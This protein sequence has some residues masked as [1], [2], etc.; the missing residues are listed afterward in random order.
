M[1]KS[2]NPL[3]DYSRY[4]SIAIQMVVIIGGGVLGGYYLDRW[5]NW[6]FPVFTVSFSFLSVALAIFIT[7]REFLRPKK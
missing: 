1:K 5:I 7:L 3:S 6:H 2:T 4:S